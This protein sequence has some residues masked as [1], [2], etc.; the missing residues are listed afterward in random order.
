MSRSR[1][2]IMTEWDDIR[3]KIAA[4]CD[5]SVPRD[6]LEGV[7][8][9]QDHIIADL[10]RRIE[11]LSYFQDAY[12]K[13]TDWLDEAKRAAGYHVNTSFDDVWEASRLAL[14][15]CCGACELFTD[16]D[17]N[18]LGWCQ[19]SDGQRACGDTCRHW[20]MRECNH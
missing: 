15:M 20:T 18:G 4:R 1:E 12:T 8:D 19:F 2:Q 9:E 5:H 10:V 11:R 7:M 3:A 17:A 16:E 13:N 6:W 14:G